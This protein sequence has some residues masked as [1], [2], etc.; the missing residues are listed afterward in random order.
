MFGYIPSARIMYSRPKP[1]KRS[2]ASRSS[3]PKSY[4]RIREILVYLNGTPVSSERGLACA[5][6]VSPSALNR[7]IQGKC[8]PSFQTMAA[9]SWVV[10]KHLGH[11]IDPRDILSFDGSYPTATVEQLLRSPQSR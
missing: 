4:N 7:I 5:I 2:R 11:R 1:Q 9:L 10:E 8:I 6:G 3:A